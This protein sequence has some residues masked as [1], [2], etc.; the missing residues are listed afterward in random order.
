MHKPKKNKELKN[1]DVQTIKHCLNY[2]WH[3]L[4][5]HQDSG[6]QGIANLADINRL[7]KLK[8]SIKKNK[9]CNYK[10][11]PPLV[12]NNHTHS[13]HLSH[14]LPRPKLKLLWLLTI[15]NYIAIIVL[16]YK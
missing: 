9:C 5:K 7:R 15:I 11:I 16:L 3:R 8:I 12:V 1:N 10:Q 4:A 6:L 14:K 13:I 2:A